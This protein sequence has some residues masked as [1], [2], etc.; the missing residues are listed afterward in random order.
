[1]CDMWPITGGCHYVGECEGY[2]SEC[3]LCPLLGGKK[4]ADLSRKAWIAKA[5]AYGDLSA[6][7]LVA[8]SSWMMQAAARSTLGARLQTHHIPNG[9]DAAAWKPL[10]QREARRS[11]GLDENHLTLAFVAD[12]VLDPRKGFDLAAAATRRLQSR[13]DRPVTLLVVGSGD[14]TDIS[15]VEHISDT[16]KTVV[17]GR[18]QDMQLLKAVY[19]AADATL[20]TSREENLANVALESMACSTPV[21]AFDIGGNSDLISRGVSGQ[22]SPPYDIGDLANGVM[23]VANDESMRIGARR[24]VEER[25]SW[26]AV[27]AQYLDVYH[28]LGAA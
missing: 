7:A 11:L 20:L 10:N 3:G 9:I 12:T 14:E 5:A 1:M 16:S 13:L 17:F 26:G 21:V 25:F 23:S 8:K 28:G 19:S 15:N 6:L 18:V 2:M 27:V 24:E 22:L 4:D